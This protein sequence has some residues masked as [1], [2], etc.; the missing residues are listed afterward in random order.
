M[1]QFVKAETTKSQQKVETGTLLSCKG[2]DYSFL[3]GSLSNK[4]PEWMDDV[5]EF[6]LQLRDDPP[7]CET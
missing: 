4:T 3:H 2:K 7:M 6:L 1:D 5:Q